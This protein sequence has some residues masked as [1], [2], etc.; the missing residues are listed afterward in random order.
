MFTTVSRC[1]ATLCLD[2]VTVV[3]LLRKEEIVRIVADLEV[4]QSFALCAL[5]APEVYSNDDDG[6]VIAP[7]GDVAPELEGPA[8]EGARMC[9]VKAL[10]VE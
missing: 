6:Y 7:N 3:V 5:T 4:C 8:L 9:P 10:R 2:G 1:C